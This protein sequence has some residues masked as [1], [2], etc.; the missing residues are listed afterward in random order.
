[1]MLRA[2]SAAGL[3]VLLLAAPAL[4]QEAIAT[5]SAEPPPGA[6]APPVAVREDPSS[7]EAIG[8]W[9]QG[10]LAG[11]PA[12]S[13]RTDAA[14]SGR[15]A[16]PADRKPHGSVWAGIG[17]GGYRNIG[18]EVTEPVGDCGQVTIAIDKTEMDVRERRRR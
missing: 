12:E 7:P 15:C 6:E 3:A 1:M 5:A 11:A 17:S 2:L 4:A 16:P 10:V 18:V 14:P 13:S 9:A 8:R